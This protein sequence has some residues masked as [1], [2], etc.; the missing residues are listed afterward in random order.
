MSAPLPLFHLQAEGDV[1]E[2]VHGLEQRVGLED[3]NRCCGAAREM[4]LTRWPRM[5][6]SPSVGI[7][8]P[9][10]I[11]STVVLPPPL[12]AEERD[13]F[14]VGDGERHLVHRGDAAEALAD[15]A[16]FDAHGR[17]GSRRETVGVGGLPLGARF[18]ATGPPLE[19]GFS[20]PSV[21]NASRASK[22]ATVNAAV[23]L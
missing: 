9:A 19:P 5:K 23:A 15:L 8:R 16:K 22:L 13:Q 7:S 11:R 20:R 2:D 14:A 3:E 10:I 12:G 4:W 1:V 17:A 21:I 18:F 6:R